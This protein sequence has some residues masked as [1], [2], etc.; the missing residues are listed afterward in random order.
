MNAYIVLCGGGVK[1]AVL[2]GCLAAAGQARVEPRGYG[3]TSAGSIVAALAALGYRPDELR[4]ELVDESFI[5]FLDDDG[6]DLDQVAEVWRKLESRATS[7]SWRTGFSL[8]ALANAFD[9][10][11]GLYDGRNLRKF[12][13]EAIEAKVDGLNKAADKVTFSDLVSFGKK[14]LRVVATDVSRKR[15]VVF[16]AGVKG[17][18]QSVV[19]AVVASASFPFVFKPV[20]IDGMQLSDGGLSSNLPSFLFAK[21]YQA[22]RVPTIAFDL[23][24]SDGGNNVEPIQDASGFLVSLR[25]SALEASDVLLREATAG[26]F[27]CPVQTPAG[28][29]TLNFRLSREQ[30]EACFDRGFGDA[31]R[32]LNEFAPI[33]RV[34]ESSEKVQEELRLM[35]GPNYLYEA[36]LRAVLHQLADV[37]EIEVGQCRAHIMLLSQRARGSAPSTRLMTYTLHMDNDTDIDLELAQDG[38]CS[39]LAWTDRMAVAD[40]DE[41]RKNPEP[42]KMTNVEHNKVPERVKSMISVSIPG[43]LHS[44]AGPALPVGTLSVDSE[45]P[46]ANTGW[47]TEDQNLAGVAPDSQPIISKDVINVLNTWASTVGLMLP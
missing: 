1:G 35:C 21:E 14:P 7:G 34:R 6:S 28:V 30:R 41:A 27:Y 39:G 11:L 22:S 2:G 4:A 37:S 32:K 26:V 23:L 40:L 13:C 45:T 36:V 16:G 31:A 38:G 46:L 17:S 8:N 33:R 29:D 25:D 42:W 3:G 5:R 10:R 15:A 47:C 18:D 44:D 43:D 20:E 12:L 24:P 9:S 19:E